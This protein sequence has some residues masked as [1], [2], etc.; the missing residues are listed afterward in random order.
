MLSRVQ[1]HCNVVS[2]LGVIHAKDHVYLIMET[3][4]GANLF[5]RIKSAGG[6]LPADVVR[7]YSG[8]VADGIAYCMSNSV[9]HRDLKPENVVVSETSSL[10]KIVDF[11]CAVSL[12]QGKLH[13]GVCGTMPFMSPEVMCGG[14]YDPSK[15][16][17]WAWALLVIEMTIGVSKFGEVLGWPR[18]VPP[19]PGRAADL[20]SWLNTP[21]FIG[22]Q[23]LPHAPVEPPAMDALVEV[24]EGALTV[25]PR[26]RWSAQDIADCRWLHK[27]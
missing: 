20:K 13:R 9:A 24:L 1:G 22:E 5:R 25:D 17:S 6:T 15:V 10:V 21:N 3:V 23:L 4:G 11:G 7:C 18:K 14:H 2:F 12:R 8:Q 26:A 27:D 16:D 19:S